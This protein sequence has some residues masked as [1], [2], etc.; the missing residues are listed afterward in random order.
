MGLTLAPSQFL[1][2]ELPKSVKAVLDEMDEFER[3]AQ[4][5]ISSEMDE[6]WPSGMKGRAGL[7]M[8]KA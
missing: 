2:D 8:L 3:K 6:A 7:A 4:R 1:T 5:P